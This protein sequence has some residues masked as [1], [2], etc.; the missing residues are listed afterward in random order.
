MAKLSIDE[1]IQ[2]LLD[3]VSHWDIHTLRSFV[4]EELEGRYDGYYERDLV[5]EY[6]NQVDADYTHEEDE[7]DDE[8]V[9]PIIEDLQPH[10][11]VHVEL[12]NGLDYEGHFRARIRAEDDPVFDDNGDAIWITTANGDD[13]YITIEDISEIWIIDYYRRP[14]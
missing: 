4:R 2:A 3:D 9:M 7:E 8:E 5:E 6:R 13:V 1:L 12:H 10:D 11:K 14:E